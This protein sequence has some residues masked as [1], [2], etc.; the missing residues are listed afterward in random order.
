MSGHSRAR[1]DFTPRK[2]TSELS[3][4][5]A[6][7]LEV[8]LSMPLARSIDPVDQFFDHR[9][10][11]WLQ[12]AGGRAEHDR[13]AEHTRP[14]QRKG[15]PR[16]AYVGKEVDVLDVGECD[17][18]FPATVANEERVTDIEHFVDQIECHLFHELI[19]GDR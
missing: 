1:G 15:D 17:P 12:Y 13:I 8:E 6:F 16:R 3:R 10:R 9:A 11:R 4:G 5:L 19:A 7:D 18:L 2:R 14:A